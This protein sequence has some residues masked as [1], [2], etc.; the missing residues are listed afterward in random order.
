[1]RDSTAPLALP[2]V[3][4]RTMGRA[5]GVLYTC[6]S[7]LALVWT[8]LPHPTDSGDPVVVAM[9]LLA[10]TFGLLMAIGV[11]DRWPTAAFHLAI[12]VIQ[13]VASVAY[14]SGGVPDN[15]V[16]LFYAWATPF[17][18]FFFGRRAALLHVGWT[19]ACML[20]AMLTMAVPPA[21]L[22]RI[23]LM[24]LGT[25]AAVGA[26]VSVV[27][28][29]MRAGRQE[30]HHAALHDPLTGLPNRRAFTEAL[31]R[32]IARQEED[33]RSVHVLLVDLDHFKLVNDTHGHHVGDQLLQGMA[34]LLDA[35]AADSGL[36]ARMG[37][38]EFSVVC[39]GATDEG[40]AA[41]VRRL[42][43]ALSSPVPTVVGPVSSA[44]SIGVAGGGSHDR[45]PR[46]AAELLREAD[47]ALYEAKETGRGNAVVFDDELHAH[48]QRRLEMDQALRG[49]LRRRELSLVYQPVVDL[50]TGR[51]T[52]AEALLR[53]R[54]PQ[55]GEVSPS[56]FVPL[57]EESGLIQDIGAW[58]LDESARQLGAWRRDDFVRDDFRV[59]VNISARQVRPA[60]VAQVAEACARHDVPPSALVLEITES[61]LLGDSAATRSTL[62]EL[63]DAG[64]GLS[65]DDFGT[66]YSSLSYLERLPL[67]AV[68]VDRSFVAGLRPGS[69]RAS[70]VAAVIAMARALDLS[71]VAEGVE[72]AE[73]AG[74]LRRLGCSHGQGFHLARPA[75]AADL[76]PGLL[77][78]LH[79]RPELLRAPFPS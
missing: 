61:V 40:V 29:R 27:A 71:V 22:L 53:W 52:G 15:D 10:L 55:L 20:G 60:L 41:L 51:W 21:V 50:A 74:L 39:E 18:A 36:V 58:V 76:L 54:S 73:V 62:R 70:L 13:L 8:V 49:A 14:V 78:D 19:G 24:T 31:G 38:D 44:G 2:D 34:P 25:V 1:M 79:Q 3:P 72:D 67:D 42:L 7:V 45:R 43:A 9:A 5:L 63:H 68:K 64:V 47:V 66:G 59:A 65:L 35:A 37:G 69:R 12:G 17:A 32:A 33:G 30:L 57:A 23:M 28:A 46:S 26:L 4:A 48:E 6:G 75:T 56:V 16:R 77:A 11:A